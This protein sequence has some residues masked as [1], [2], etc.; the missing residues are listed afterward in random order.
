MMLRGRYAAGRWR[1][2]FKLEGDDDGDFV[3][4]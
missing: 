4:N 1:H 2:P 3:V